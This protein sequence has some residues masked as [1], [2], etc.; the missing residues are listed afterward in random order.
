MNYDDVERKLIS[1]GTNR[2]SIKKIKTSFGNSF[3]PPLASRV[4]IYSRSPYTEADGLASDQAT[5]IARQWP[6]NGE[7][8][9][10]IALDYLYNCETLGHTGNGTKL[11]LN[12]TSTAVFEGLGLSVCSSLGNRPFPVPLLLSVHRLLRIRHVLPKSP[13]L[14]LLLEHL[15][16]LSGG[17]QPIMGQDL[18]RS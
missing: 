17:L 9:I 7:H 4:A 6:S 18:E 15:V 3:S 1:V 11:T 8:M 14:D 10:R 12:T 13:G 5:K 16:Q 2:R